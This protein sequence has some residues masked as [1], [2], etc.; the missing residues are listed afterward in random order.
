MSEINRR[1]LWFA[2]FFMLACGAG[3]KAAEGRDASGSSGGTGRDGSGMTDVGAGGDT[4]DSGAVAATPDLE[5]SR[6]DASNADMAVTVTPD[7][8]VLADSSIAQSDATAVV[9]ATTFVEF[10][11]VASVSGT[12]GHTE[13]D[14][15]YGS[16]GHVRLQMEQFGTSFQCYSGM[17]E[18]FLKYDRNGEECTT[19]NFTL[20][21]GR[22]DYHGPGEY[23]HDEEYGSV[24]GNPN[25][26]AFPS[27]YVS[28][29]FDTIDGASSRLNRGTGTI[30]CNRFDIPVS[31]YPGCRGLRN[32][33]HCPVTIERHDEAVVS[34][35][36]DCTLWACEDW[37]HLRLGSDHANI[38]TEFSFSGRFQYRPEDC[39]ADE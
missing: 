25:A 9:D 18:V 12:G 23:P 35:S 28:L 19:N 34:G 39:A 29:G 11:Y 27:G 33:W 6:L 10:D 17:E 16:T 1:L 3:E 26:N 36:F 38:V 24:E 13:P 31:D 15:A 5:V 22:L 37:D 2:A 20:H 21:I 8:A 7:A 14:D 32:R 30:E 4:G